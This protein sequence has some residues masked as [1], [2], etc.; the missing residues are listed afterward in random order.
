MKLNYKISILIVMVLV[1]IAGYIEISASEEV[2]DNRYLVYNGG[3]TFGYVY[4]IHDETREV[5]CWIS[6]TSTG[7]GSGGGI[8]C[9]PDSQLYK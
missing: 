2:I 4:F 5:S 1:I 6:I 7:A 9:I 3:S 8:S